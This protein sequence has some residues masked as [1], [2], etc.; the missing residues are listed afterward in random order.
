MELEF[1]NINNIGNAI[2]WTLVH[3]L[4][5]GTLLFLGYFSITRLF[6]K[7]KINLQYWAGIATMLL[8]LILPIRELLFQL[9]EKSSLVSYQLSPNIGV[10]NSVGIIDSNGLYFALVQK[11]I[12]YLVILWAIIVIL[13]SSHLTQSWFKLVKLSKVV[14]IEIPE[15]L[16]NKL[17]Y[18][19]NKLKI[20]FKPVITISKKICT[21]DPVLLYIDA[22]LVN[23]FA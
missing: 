1:S 13:I 6:I 20:K 10:I 12:P 3:F 15:N 19:S 23:A 5:Q 2:G 17:A 4:W 11:I 14:S 9:G 16:I 8:C 18:A 21:C 7:N 22:I